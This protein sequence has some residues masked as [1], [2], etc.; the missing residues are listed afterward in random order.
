MIRKCIKKL[1]SIIQWS[2]RFYFAHFFVWLMWFENI[3]FFG[4][5]LFCMCG[6]AIHNIT[7]PNP[8]EYSIN[9]SN[10][11]DLIGFY[12]LFIPAISGFALLYALIPFTLIVM[13]MKYLLKRKF[14][15]TGKFLLENAKYNRF[16][17]IG[18]IYTVLMW[19]FELVSG[20]GILMLSLAFI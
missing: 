10:W 20:I 17:K 3:L 16:Y 14:T 18:F 15:V 2:K 12:F 13:L 4:T 9:S 19:L 8:V 5:F 1:D 6:D 11:T 7:S